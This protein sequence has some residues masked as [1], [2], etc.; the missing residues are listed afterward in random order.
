MKSIIIITVILFMTFTTLHAQWRE[1]NSPTSKEITDIHFVDSEYGF[2][3]CA[4]GTV[5]KTTNGGLDWQ[6]FNTGI[7]ASFMSI[8]GIDKDTVYT[9]R[10]SLYK[11][12]NSCVSWVDYGGLGSSGSTIFDIHFLS[13]KT[14]FIIKSGKLYKTNDYGLNWYKV[15][16]N[17]YSGGNIIFTSQDTGYVVG[18]ATIICDPGPC[19]F[20]FNYGAII[21]TTDGG[22]SWQKLIFFNDTLNII[23]ASF[24]DNNFGYCFSSNN[25]IQKTEDGGLT[26]IS[27][28]TGITGNI[29][30]GLF[31]NKSIGFITNIGQI[32]QIYI[33][34]NGGMDWNLEYT[35]SDGGLF[36]I[37]SSNK[38]VVA[39]G[40]NGLICV[41][42]LDDL[43]I[44]SQSEYF[45]S[46]EV[47]IYPNPANSYVT[48][49]H[50]KSQAV[51]YLLT[52]RDIKGQAVLSEK[53]VFN[54]VYNMDLNNIKGGIYFL[55]LTNNKEQV[56]KKIVIQN[57]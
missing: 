32:G 2:M 49:Q 51:Q 17:V 7:P 8:F 38:M 9:A 10:N 45:N 28:D 41:R 25:T 46:K 34:T 6:A 47:I 3:S 11:S 4:S 21:K 19:N 43:T 5:L 15:Y 1:V 30:G 52:L 18:G 31:I 29:S 57:K 39:G 40:P 20:P 54:N 26:W 37:G 23:S 42:N 24:I 27:I 50:K 53:V 44:N 33:T 16:E 12:T 22:E 14:G 35:V 36:E 56:V 13:S 48:I 55:T